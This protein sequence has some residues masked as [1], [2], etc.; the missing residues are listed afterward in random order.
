MSYNFTGYNF[1]TSPQRLCIQLLKLL[2]IF[3]IHHWQ[4]FLPNATKNSHISV[5]FFHSLDHCNTA[6]HWP[7]ETPQGKTESRVRIKAQC[8]HT[9]RIQFTLQLNC[10]TE[11][12]CRRVRHLTTDIKTQLVTTYQ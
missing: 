7:A 1:D 2:T 4:D 9:R 8:N 5:H 11:K 12:W 10:S 6:W 3:Y